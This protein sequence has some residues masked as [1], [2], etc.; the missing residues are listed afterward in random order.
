MAYTTLSNVQEY[1]GVEFDAE[2][3]P[4]VTTVNGY[5]SDVDTEIDNLTGTTFG[6][7]IETSEIISING[8]SNVFVTKKYPIYS[9][10]SVEKNTNSDRFDTPVWVSVPFYNDIFKIVTKYNYSGD[11]ALKLTYEYGFDAIPPEVEFLATLLVAQKI[12]QAEYSSSGTTSS[13]SV[14]SISITNNISA[15]TLVNLKN[16]IKEYK[17]RVGRYKNFC[18]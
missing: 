5:I 1:L 12:I 18:E 7:P 10:T 4:T 16:E 11:R 2:S 9:V 14:G 17:R 6:T 13:I 15:S 8:N 3:T